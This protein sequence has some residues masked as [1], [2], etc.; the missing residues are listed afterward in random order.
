MLPA[1]P[2]A[3]S[4]EHFGLKETN[5]SHLPRDIWLHS[6]PIKRLGNHTTR[7]HQALEVGDRG[8]PNNY[9]HEIH[10]GDKSLFGLRR[11]EYA[12]TESSRNLDWDKRF[13]KGV[14]T[15]KVGTTTKSD[16]EIVEAGE[17]RRRQDLLY[18]VLFN[19]CQHFTDGLRRDIT[20]TRYPY[21]DSLPPVERL[22][23]RIPGARTVTRKASSLKHRVAMTAESV[24]GKINPIEA[25]AMIRGRELRKYADRR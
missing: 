8:H 19:N 15:R 2:P 20:D 22:K 16:R 7:V 5:P 6:K 4:L 3:R 1:G 11:L 12:A 13:V 24:R 25:A 23:D 21:D 10:K 9:I 14:S 17:N 18:S